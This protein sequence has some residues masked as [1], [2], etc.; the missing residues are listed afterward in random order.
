M[1]IDVKKEKVLHW[2]KKRFDLRGKR[3]QTGERHSGVIAFAIPLE[4]EFA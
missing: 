4:C 1:V 2:Q 3:K